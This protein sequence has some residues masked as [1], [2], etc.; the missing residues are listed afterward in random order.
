MIKFFTSQKLTE[1]S[2]IIHQDHTISTFSINTYQNNLNKMI[3]TALKVMPAGITE[4]QQRDRI[5]RIKASEHIIR[6]QQCQLGVRAHA[7]QV[8]PCQI[9]NTVSFHWN[10]N[11]ANI[12]EHQLEW[13]IKSTLNLFPCQFWLKKWKLSNHALQTGTP[14]H[15]IGRVFTDG[16]K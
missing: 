10:K 8:P 9:N 5:R 12:S 16:T 7:T 14:R 1:M 2:T 4:D 6:L 15:I 3:K 13:R 11:S